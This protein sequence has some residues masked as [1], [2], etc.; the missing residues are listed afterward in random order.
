MPL[1]HYAQLQTLLGYPVLDF[2][3]ILKADHSS[4]VADLSQGPDL[5]IFKNSGPR[6]SE[7]NLR[8]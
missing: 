2:S 3:K 4:E 1:L 5:G 8:I 6:Y 7:W